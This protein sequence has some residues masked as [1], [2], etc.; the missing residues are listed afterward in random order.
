MALY[1]IGYGNRDWDQFYALLEQYKVELLVDVR[2][3]P[4][5]GYQECFSRGQLQQALEEVGIEY[6][7]MGDL[8]GGRPD[9]DYLYDEQGYVD[10]LACQDDLLFQRGFK[11]LDQWNQQGKRVVLMCSELRPEECHRSR[12]LGEGLEKLGIPLL[13]IEEGGE[14]IDQSTVRMRLQLGQPSLFEDEVHPRLQR[15]DR[16][17]RSARQ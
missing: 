4:Q 13:H 8:L 6:Q 1:T 5:A 15:S 16:P 12:I 14:Q 17:L 7:W 3:V 9:Q 10:Y 2:S 11:Q